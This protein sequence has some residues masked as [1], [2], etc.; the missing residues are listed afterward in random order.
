MYESYWTN[1]VGIQVDCVGPNACINDGGNYYTHPEN[2][3]S[4]FYKMCV[5]CSS[6]SDVTVGKVTTPGYTTI[7]V[8]SNSMPT[9]CYSVRQAPNQSLVNNSQTYPVYRNLDFTVTWNPNVWGLTSVTAA[10][11]AT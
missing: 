11:V 5:S 7:R 8:Q 9:H 6:V 4:H 3:C 10:E 1:A 2:K